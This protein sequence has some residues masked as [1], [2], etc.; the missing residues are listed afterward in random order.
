MVL[1]TVDPVAH[2][3]AALNP[4]TPLPRELEHTG[5]KGGAPAWSDDPDAVRNREHQ[6]RWRAKQRGA[7]HSR[8]V[9]PPAAA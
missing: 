7:E 6:A 1:Y 2:A 8:R 3:W 9:V 4:R 5:R